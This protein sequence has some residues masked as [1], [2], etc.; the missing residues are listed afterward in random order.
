MKKVFRV[1]LIIDQ[2]AEK[3]RSVELFAVGDPS[4]NSLILNLL[5]QVLEMA[6]APN[7]ENPDFF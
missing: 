6:E 1:K 4:D 5:S 2:G 3:E 7:I